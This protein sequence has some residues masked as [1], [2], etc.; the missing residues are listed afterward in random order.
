MYLQWRTVAWFYAGK[1]LENYLPEA[2]SHETSLAS[3]SRPFGF[4]RR[5]MSCST[6]LMTLVA[7]YV[8]Q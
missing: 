2:E 5:R 7:L 6:F 8:Q 1:H 4:H 3:V